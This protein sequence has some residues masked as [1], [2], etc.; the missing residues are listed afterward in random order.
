VRSPLAT[1][2]AV[3]SEPPVEA[4]ARLVENLG[5]DGRVR[6]LRD[7]QYLAWR[8][9]N[10]LSIYR[11]LLRRSGCEAE[12]YLVLQAARSR[13]QHHARVVDWEARDERVAGELLGAAKA[14]TRQPLAVWSSGLSEAR[15]TLLA[16]EGFRVA[17]RGRTRDYRPTLLVRELRA[18]SVGAG[19]PD[20]GDLGSWDL[21]AVFGD[22]V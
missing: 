22:G 19:A 18:G 13:L 3:S 11:F 5:H 10:P 4:M 17:P 2:I 1:G 14:L 7:R 21:R 20:L 15:R 6:H 16:S 9:R 12:G 8:Y